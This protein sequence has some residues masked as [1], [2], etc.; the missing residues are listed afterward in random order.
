MNLFDPIL[1]ESKLH[2]NFKSVITEVKEEERAELLRWAKGF[3]DRDGK[4]V[5]EFQSTF[6]SSFWELYLYAVFKEYGFKVDWSHMSPDFHIISK[7]GDFIVEA[8][9]ANSAQGKSNEWDRSWS[10]EELQGISFNEL[11]RESIIR[12]ANSLVS[13][14]KTFQNNYSG[15]S[16]VKGKPFV[17]AVAPFEQPYFNLQYNR[18]IMAL[19]YDHYVDEDEYL[20]SP[21][22][23]PHGPPSKQL[24]FVEKENGAE[25]PLGFFN[26]DQFSE[27]SAIIFSCTATWG[28][29]DALVDNPR[30]TRRIDSVWATEPHGAS[31]KRSGSREE[32]AENLTDGLQVYHNPYA[33]YPLPPETFRRKGV[34]QCFPDPSE[35]QFMTEEMTRCLQ[36][37][38]VFS[39]IIK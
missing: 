26:D 30:V 9:T 16:H 32:H 27:L 17:L 39:F 29:L 22:S 5:K 14:C 10:S 31:E 8:T 6:N 21:E 18:P 38:Q 35:R 3:P 15:L 34:V 4:F 33:K 37:R 23:F 24:G 25:I 12:L 2:Q 7:K 11:N 28:K 36:F 19:L 1:P 20:K 13:K